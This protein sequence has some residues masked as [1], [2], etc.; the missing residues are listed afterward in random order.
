MSKMSGIGGCTASC[1]GHNTMHAE[2]SNSV[3]STIQILFKSINSGTLPKLKSA[4]KI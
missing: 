3:L 4:S 1:S 2:I